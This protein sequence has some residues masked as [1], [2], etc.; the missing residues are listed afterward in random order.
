MSSEEELKGKIARL[1]QEIERLK[2]ENSGVGQTITKKSAEV[3]GERT[4]IGIFEE[5]I[6]RIGMSGGMDKEE[7]KITQYF[8]P[9]GRMLIKGKVWRCSSCNSIL[10][11]EEKIE[12]NSRIYCEQ[13]YRKEH[14]VDKN[15]YK[16][17]VC[18]W[19]GF[20]ETSTFLEAFGFTVT[21][22]RVTGIPEKEAKKRVKKLLERGYLFFHGMFFRE[23]RVSSKGEEA[24]AAYNQI[25]RRDE[26]CNR[27]RNTIWQIEVR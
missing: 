25:Y 20:T 18:I 12:A 1:K 9:K 23:L 13:C 27:V 19:R 24:L 16:I 4:E 22:Q 15:D 17:L 26:D 21:I 5:E 2:I 14:D 11:E 10:T 3:A 6:R 7:V 8:S